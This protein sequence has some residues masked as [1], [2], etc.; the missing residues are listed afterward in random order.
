MK[1]L[2]WILII[3]T[4]FSQEKITGFK[5][6]SR[7]VGDF[8][9]KYELSPYDKRYANILKC[10]NLRSEKVDG[11]YPC[12]SIS[13]NNYYNIL[14]INE[15][16]LKKERK[17]SIISGL[18]F[19]TA[20]IVSRIPYKCSLNLLNKKFPNLWI[21][22]RSS[23]KNFKIPFSENF[24]EYNSPS[25]SGF[26][27]NFIYGGG[28]LYLYMGGAK[29]LGLSEEADL[30]LQ[31]KQFLEYLEYNI[32]LS[33]HNSFIAFTLEKDSSFKNMKIIEEKVLKLIEKSNW[34]ELSNYKNHYTL[35]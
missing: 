16:F 34:L 4:C 18:S 12:E 29:I 32:S 1:W 3:P 5:A 17:D 14:D 20:M 30:E 22:K 8:L 13:K 28:V 31:T 2:F 24:F 26:I 10:S 35:E 9:I 7:L 6:K 19:F 23:K 33:N 21:F 27:R 15:A 25:L 11:K